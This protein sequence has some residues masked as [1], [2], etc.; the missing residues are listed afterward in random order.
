[1]TRK[2][3]S[4]IDSAAS[5]GRQ[6]MLTYLMYSLWPPLEAGLTRSTFCFSI[7]RG[8]KL[9]FLIYPLVLMRWSPKEITQHQAQV[10]A[11]FTFIEIKKLWC[12]LRVY[13][14]VYSH[15]QPK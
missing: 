11:F 4:E 1:L 13:F 5:S 7:K 2:S 15:T 10:R 14:T 8:G 3:D 9:S 6:G 12:C